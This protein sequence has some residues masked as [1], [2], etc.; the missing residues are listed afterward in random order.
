[1]IPRSSRL[2][3]WCLALLLCLSLYYKSRAPADSGGGA[4]FL[5]PGKP[6]GAL[7]RLAGDFPRPGLYRFPDGAT[8]TT[9][10]NMTLPAGALPEGVKRVSN[11]AL[12]SG[13]LLTLQL[14]EGKVRELSLTAMEVKERM[15]LG[16]PLDPDLLDAAEWAELPGIGPVLSERIVADRHKNGAFGSLEGVLRVPGVGPRKLE[17]ISSYF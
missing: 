9:A 16:I 2:A 3:L 14:R 7:V 4:A 13:D 1:V 11:H 8:L 12:A 6:G 5:R 17:G 10:I 15:L